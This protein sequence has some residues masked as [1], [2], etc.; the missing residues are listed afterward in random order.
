MSNLEILVRRLT[1]GVRDM[2]N[3]RLINFLNQLLSN[4][5]VLYVKLHRY[6]WF[7][8]GVHFFTLHDKF[9]EMY[10]QIA[11]Q[12]DEIAERILMIGGKPL[13]TM[14]KYIKESTIEEAAAD[15]EEA[16][17]IQQ[18]VKNITQL[19]SEIQKEGYSLTEEFH[20]H[21]TEDLLTSLHADLDKKKW[22]LE[23]YQ[24]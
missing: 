20:D 1:F 16:E 17:I 11:V 3:Q 2:D 8:K 12:L 22:M 4:Y 23:S 24:K 15:D 13:A 19:I 14:A 7:V 5:F 6:H 9:E 18:L 21:P 10:E